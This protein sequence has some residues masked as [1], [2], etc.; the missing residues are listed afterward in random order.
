MLAIL[1]S[2]DLI[3]D[4][5]ITGDRKRH[6]V[7][8]SIKVK[9]GS[10]EIARFLKVARSCICKVEMELLNERDG[11]ELGTTRKRTGHYQRSDSL[12]HSEHL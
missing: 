2:E 5:T 1:E 8:V 4:T 10:L 6:A 9:H 7:I 3:S 12:T 11:D